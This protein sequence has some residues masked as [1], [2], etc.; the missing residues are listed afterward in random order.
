M[1]AGSVNIV[2]KNLS[3]VPRVKRLLQVPSFRDSSANFCT[4]SQR[5]ALD[6]LVD[7]SRSFDV[8]WMFMRHAVT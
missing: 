3:T 1:A 2:T 8:H 7:T 4:L 5:D 6:G